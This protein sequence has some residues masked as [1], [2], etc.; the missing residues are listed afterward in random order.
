MQPVSLITGSGRGIGRATAIAL[1]ARGHRLAL[2]SRSMDELEETARLCK[3]ESLVVPA[4]ICDPSAVLGA[5]AQTHERFGRID[6]LIHNAGMAQLGP[7]DQL[8]PQQ[9]QTTIDT[10]LSAAYHFCH[11]LWPIW[12]KQNSGVAVF[13][14][15]AAARDPFAGLAAY[16]AAKAGLNLLGLALAREGAAIGLRVHTVAPGA[17][18]TKMLRSAF[19]TDQFPSDQTLD[20]SDVAA[21]IAQCVAG[22]L[23]HTSGEVIYVHK[24]A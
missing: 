9:W 21:V 24:H 2:V 19:T 22:D 12:R 14:S 20:P 10:N 18:E 5:I 13:V 8:T 3:T 7:F 1:S 15:S 11:G 23:R 4:D 6:A 17:V 16:G